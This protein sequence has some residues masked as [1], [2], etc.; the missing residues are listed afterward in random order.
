[1]LTKLKAPPSIQ[2]GASF[3]N[4]DQL[5]ISDKYRRKSGKKNAS[6]FTEFVIFRV[7]EKEEYCIETTMDEVGATSLACDMCEEEVRTEMINEIPI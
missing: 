1:M 3:S 7:F 4:A 5:L 6:F 2:Y